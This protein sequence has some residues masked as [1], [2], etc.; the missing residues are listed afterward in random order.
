[1][2]VNHVRVISIM[3]IESLRKYRNRN[4][5]GYF[6]NLSPSVRRTAYHGLSFFLER[7]RRQGLDTPQ[8]LF[9]I[10]VGQAKRLTLNPPTSAWGRSMLG[11]K[12]GKAVQEKYRMEG[13]HPT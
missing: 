7:Q 6:A 11:K 3:R 4:P 1:M 8:W 13:R 5:G 12:G 2:T 10:L 9:A